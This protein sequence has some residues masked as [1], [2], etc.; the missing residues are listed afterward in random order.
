MQPSTFNWVT[1]R[2]ACSLAAVFEALKLE[3]QADVK[4]RMEQRLPGAQYRFSVVSR[5][6]SFTVLLNGNSV[7]HKSVTFSLTDNSVQVTDLNDKIMF[8]ATLTLNDDGECR[9]K[10]D[11]RE[12]DF[13]QVRRMALED[14]FFGDVWNS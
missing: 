14:L 13:W 10:V 4:T 3:V 8:K 2:A 11:G 9:F 5:G 6:G 7:Q 12:R 1:E